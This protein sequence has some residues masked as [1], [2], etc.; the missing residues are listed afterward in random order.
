MHARVSLLLLI[1]FAFA[2][3]AHAAPSCQL[4]PASPTVTIC[5]PANGAGIT[6][7]V[8]INAGTTDAVNPVRLLQVYV[9]G[10]K[11]NEIAADN[12][13]TYLGMSAGAHRVTVQATD[14]A[15]TVFKS[16]INITVSG[17]GTPAACTLNTAS[18]SVTICTPLNG[19][20]G[21]SPI[22][23]RAGTTD[24]AS[25]VKLMQIYV[26]GVKKYQISANS[27]DA[28]I[29]LPAGSHRVAVQ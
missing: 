1:S 15:N 23:V 4:N 14:T 27:V 22:Q 13:D 28:P 5:S 20:S 6:S 29:D 24:A 25:P 3:S 21:Q 16:T 2:I 26:D 7:P 10:A 18:P 8:Q 17:T 12:L 9:D 11:K 19:S